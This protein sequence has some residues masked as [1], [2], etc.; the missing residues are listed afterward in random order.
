M[1][2]VTPPAAPPLINK[3]FKLATAWVITKNPLWRKSWWSLDL[4]VKVEIWS[5]CI[6]G[7]LWRIAFAIL[8]SE[9]SIST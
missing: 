9:M 5:G 4:W 3:V 8:T 6:Q 1:L 7:I 2:V